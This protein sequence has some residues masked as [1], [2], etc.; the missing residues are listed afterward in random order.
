MITLRGNAGHIGAEYGKAFAEKIRR[1]VSILVWREGCEPLPRQEK[2]FVEWV[3][4]QSRAFTQG[5]PWLV[6]EMEAV[7][8]ATGLKY[9]DIF[10]LNLRAW[11]FEFYGAQPPLAACSSL[12]ITLNDGTVACAGA[13][14]DPIEYYC[15]PVRYVP[16]EGYSLI[17]FPMTGTS[18]G[19]RGM[20]SAGLSVGISSQVLPGLRPL[21]G[22][23][24]QDLAL[25]VMLQM[26][27]T[28]EE[29]REFCKTY[30]FTM[31]VVCVDAQGGVFCAQQTAAGLHEIPCDGSCALT[32]HVASDELKAKLT[33]RGVTEFP[34]SDT[35]RPRLSKLLDF[36]RERNG[37]CTSDEVK[38]VIGFRD[39][40]DPATIHNKGSM[41]LTYSN[42]QVD[43]CTLWIA[44][45]GAEANAVFEPF[46]VSEP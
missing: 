7:A 40:S 30:P 34:E 5:W 21:P 1:N 25:R 2:R 16:D 44:T 27:A 23:I 38:H 20:N 31:N 14:D 11:Q 26:C 29:V 12:A 18:W 37:K 45:P 39:D 24:N 22:A 41:Y 9:E 28:V 6:E 43:P 19:N 4:E 36:A 42:P 33:A 35:T 17:T 46:C 3:D 13:L 10:L 32:N 8:T 15:G